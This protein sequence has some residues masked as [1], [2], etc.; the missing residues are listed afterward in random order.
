LSVLIFGA[1]DSV[2]CAPGP[3]SLQQATLE[4]SAG[5]LHYNSLDCPVSQ[6]SNDSLHANGRL[7]RATVLNNTAT[8]VRAFK[9]EGTRL[10]GVAPD[11]PVHKDDKRLPWSTAANP[12]GCAD[13]AHTEQC[14]VAVRWCTGLSGGTPDCPVR[15]SPTVFANS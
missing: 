8:G 5:A 12:N 4:N 14:T 11:Y 10:S 13:V 6:R 7:H 15:P 1:L 3:Y 2:W 9:S